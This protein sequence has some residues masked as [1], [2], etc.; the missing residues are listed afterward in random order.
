MNFEP[1]CNTIIYRN[2]DKKT[3]TSTVQYRVRSIVGLQGGRQRSGARTCTRCFIKED[4][5]FFLSQFSQMMI[6]LHEISNSCSR[7]NVNSK[8]DSW[9]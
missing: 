2:T 8:H 9:L 6:T 4:P 5:F 3:T 1:K 7:R